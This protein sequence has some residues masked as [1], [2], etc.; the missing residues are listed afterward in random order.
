MFDKITQVIPVIQ[1]EGPKVGVPSLLIRFRDCNLNCPFCDTQWSNK[2]TEANFSWNDIE[3]YLDKYPHIDN[4]MITG[5]EPFLYAKQIGELIS[6]VIKKRENQ[7]KTLEI[8]SN[9]TLI[10]EVNCS[11][12]FIGIPSGK[13]KKSINVS[14]KL[15]PECYSERR[16]SRDILDTYAKNSA[17]LNRLSGTKSFSYIYKIVYQKEWIDYIYEFLEKIQLPHDRR[18]PSKRIFIMP[19][20]P[21]YRDY[22]LSSPEGQFEFNN[23]FRESCIDTIQFCLKTGYNFSPREHVWIYLDAKNEQ[24]EVT[25]D[26]E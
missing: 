9:G 7:I 6:E 26:A 5:G 14:P 24:I 20:S 18:T 13:I 17:T 22:D 25:K 4:I 21:D 12:L 2:H 11:K 10:N 23:K 3:E 16:S 19:I 1:G 15:G 8:E